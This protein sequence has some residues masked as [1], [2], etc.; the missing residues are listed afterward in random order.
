VLA[1][2]AQDPSRPQLASLRR[3]SVEA[4]AL[5]K[6]HQGETVSL[7][8][9][10][11]ASAVKTKVIER[12]IGETNEGPALETAEIVVSGG[13]AFDD[14]EEFDKYLTHGL[15]EVLGAAVGATR[16][17]VDAGIKPEQQQIGL[18]G[19]IVGPNLYIAVGLSGA[20]QHMAGCTGSKNIVAINIDE[21]AQIFKFAKFGIVGD[22]KKILPPLIEKLK[23]V[24][25]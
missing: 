4:L 5:D 7:A 19:K 24:R 20:I 16:G 22:Y 9:D 10:V 25:Q 6:D 14:V 12:V 18:T 17:A 15:A 1:T 8:A 23:E 13:R 11:D 3:S 21:Y 2:Y